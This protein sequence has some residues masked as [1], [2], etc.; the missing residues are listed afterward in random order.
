MMVVVMPGMLT[1]LDSS[2]RCLFRRF[3]IFK[4]YIGCHSPE[5]SFLKNVIVSDEPFKESRVVVKH[6][7]VEARIVGDGHEDFMRD[8]VRCAS[9][10]EEG[11]KTDE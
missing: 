9:V 5:V 11:R 1:L 8:L 6:D 10:P 7:G 2:D 4:S 3:G